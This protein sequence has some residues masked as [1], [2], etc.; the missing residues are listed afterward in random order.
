MHPIFAVL[1]SLFDG[2]KNLETVIKEFAYSTG[3][4]IVEVRA[5]VSQLIEN[6]KGVDLYFN[7]YTFSFPKNTLIKKAGHNDLIRYAPSDFLLPDSQLDF[8]TTRL[9]TPIE[10]SLFLNNTCATRCIYCNVDK[11]RRLSTEIPFGR[12]V[13]LIAEAKDLGLRSFNVSG[14]EIFF[15]KHW[16]ELLKT[17]VDKGFDPYVSTKF[18]LNPER[19]KELR[20]CGINRIQL[21]I[22]T[23]VEDEMSKMLG[24]NKRY[25]DLFFKTLEHLDKSNFEIIVN[26][27]I[28]SI[29]Q[30]NIDKL[31]DYLLKFESVKLIRAA[32]TGF[33]V[34]KDTYREIRPGKEK[35]DE[36]NNMIAQLKDKYRDKVNMT[37]YRYPEKRFYVNSSLQ[38]KHNYYEARPNCTGN[39]QAFCILSDGQ[40]TICEELYWHPRFIIGDL[41]KQ[42][43]SEVWNSKEAL[44]LYNLSKD[45][46]SPESKCKSCD[47]FDSCHQEKGVCWKQVIYS[48]GNENWDYPDPRCH[49]APEPRNPLWIE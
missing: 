13:E 10:L 8:E 40:A 18:P 47:V 27:Q 29:N 49:H 34:Y 36:I 22:D 1:L 42:S 46:V 39:F 35:M 44:G 11:R 20:E 19:I 38:E 12:I 41:K 3:L 6:E 5:I 48:Y 23:V 32:A 25:Y 45:A 21:S 31:F 30:N 37:P 14:G 43:I 28:T 24:I 26:S 9:Y 7:N 4:D 2:K 16:K 33:S 15:Y 17:L